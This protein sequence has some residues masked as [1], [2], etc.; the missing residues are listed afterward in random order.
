MAVCRIGDDIV[1]L[2]T[3]LADLSVG[4]VQPMPPQPITM[5][6]DRRLSEAKS[7]LTDSIENLPGIRQLFV[8]SLVK[9]VSQ[10]RIDQSRF[11]IW[12]FVVSSVCY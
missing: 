5:S 8:A 9:S 2:A 11:V 3:D 12:L 7:L 6:R 1:S 10:R 4:S